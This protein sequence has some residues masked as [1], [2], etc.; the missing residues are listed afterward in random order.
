MVGML[1]ILARIFGIRKDGRGGA[2]NTVLQI[3]WDREIQFYRSTGTEKYSFT[4]LP[5]PCIKNPM[6]LKS[7]ILKIPYAQNLILVRIFR[8]T[9]QFWPL[10]VGFPTVWFQKFWSRKVR[11]VCRKNFHQISCKFTSTVTIYDQKNKKVNEY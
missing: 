3:Y 6:Y 5:G 11:E 8:L 1:G 2:G 10:N 4:G 9:R 7:H